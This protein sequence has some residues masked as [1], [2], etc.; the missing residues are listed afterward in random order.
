LKEGISFI[1][2]G[3]KWNK[4]TC[5]LNIGVFSPLFPWVYCSR[6]KMEGFLAC[7]TLRKELLQRKQMQV[8]Y[9]ANLCHFFVNVM[10]ILCIR[11]EYHRVLPLYPSFGFKIQN[12]Q[13]LG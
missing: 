4:K 9:D 3:W 11:G 6:L 7:E 10:L 8:R 1:L 5:L 2:H 12:L 13:Y